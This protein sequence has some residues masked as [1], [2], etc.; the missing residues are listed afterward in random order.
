MSWSGGLPPR[1]NTKEFYPTALGMCKAHLE[2]L[3]Q[4]VDKL[5]TADKVMTDVYM[6]DVKMSLKSAK[7]LLEKIGK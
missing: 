1:S 5:L 6:R 7:E 4:N 2:I 3:V